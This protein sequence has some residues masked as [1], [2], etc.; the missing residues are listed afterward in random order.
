VGIIGMLAAR[1]LGR[2]IGYSLLMS[3]GTLLAV[4]AFGDAGVLAGGLFYLTVSTLAAGALYLLAGMIGPE[5]D[6]IEEPVV[7]E[8][9]NP[10]AD[11]LYTEDDERTVRIPAP[12]GILSGGF[13]IAALMIAGLPPLPGFLAKFAMLAPLLQGP[14]GP[15]GWAAWL[16]AALVILSS[17]FALVALARAGIQIWWADDHPVPPTI[18]LGEVAPL[19]LLL[20]ACLLLAVAVEGPFGFIQRTAAQLIG[21]GPYIEAVLGTAGRP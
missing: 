8:P 11:G 5:R 7:L 20:A 18:R 14:A 9:Y 6:D 16:L 10:E 3:S 1:D 2:L 12:I 4:I 21:S 17:L 15:F 19:M 13:L